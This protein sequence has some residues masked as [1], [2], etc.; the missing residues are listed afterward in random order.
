MA[1]RVKY[2]AWAALQSVLEKVLPKIE[3]KLVIV[4]Y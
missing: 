1:E 3:P 4:A 2:K